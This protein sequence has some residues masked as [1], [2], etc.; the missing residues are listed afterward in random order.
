MCI[1]TD[2]LLVT[3]PGRACKSGIAIEVI[4]IGGPKAT[5]SFQRL[6]LCEDGEN[7]LLLPTGQRNEYSL[8][9]CCR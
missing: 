7:R 9:M 1:C 6:D 8:P 3:N 4:Y 5:S 2:D